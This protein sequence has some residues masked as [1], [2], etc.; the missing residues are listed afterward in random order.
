MRDHERRELLV[1]E[2]NLLAEA[3]ELAARFDGLA[4]APRIGR[5]RRVA[6]WLAVALLLLGVLLGDA[7]LLLGALLLARTT[8]V[9][10]RVRAAPVDELDRRRP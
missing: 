4:E 10:R 7:W 8:V 9:P 1:I 2:E 3:P 6:W 5:R